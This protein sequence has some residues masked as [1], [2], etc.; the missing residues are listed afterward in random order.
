MNGFLATLRRR[1]V[2]VDPRASLAA[3]VAWLI[4]LLSLTFAIAA[5]MWV[6]RI[7]R[8]NVLQ[9]HT[10]RLALE[11]D[12]LSVA[13]GQ[14]LAARLDALSAVR[15][16][17]SSGAAGAPADAARVYTELRTHYPELD[18]LF[19][20][21]RDGA[22]HGDGVA[23]SPGRVA[24]ESWF[25][26][27]QSAPWIG[28][29][30]PAPVTA[31][32]RADRVSTPQSTAA[33]TDSLGELAAPIEDGAGHAVAVAVARLSWPR[34]LGHPQRLTDEL[35]PTAKARVFLLDER[36]H[37]LLGPAGFVGETWRGVPTTAVD[38]GLD[39]E[40]LPDG[41]QILV[42]REP[43]VSDPRWASRGWTVLLA[44]PVAR[45]YRRADA[46]AYQILLVSIALGV[47][48]AAL[49]IFGAQRLT[50]GLN[51]LTG[52]VISLGAHA[53]GDIAIPDGQDEVATLA[54]AF[55]RI[56]EDL[57]RERGELERLSADLE[58][59]VA[60]RTAEVQR[61]A[62]ESRYAAIVRERLQIARDLHDTL[63][64][65]L[66][67]LLSEIRL[68]R[69]LARR[70]P[71]A[72]EEELKRAEQIA[73]DGLNDARAAIEQMRDHPVREVG[74]GPVLARELERLRDRTG[75]QVEFHADPAAAG[76]GE[77]RAERLLRM[78]L[79]CLRNVERHARA[80]LVRLTLRASADTLSMLIEDDGIGF[81]VAAS[82]PGHYGLVGLREQAEMIGATLRLVSAPDLGTTVEITLALA[83]VPFA[84]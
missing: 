16:L 39:F 2:R 70:D 54:R 44:E 75:L 76:F 29:L 33:D 62:E 27:A 84:A 5:A 73:R 7:A 32:R 67:A 11:T 58:R 24:A 55:A 65:S 31:G 17:V 66:M 60:V 8:S 77:E 71:R 49:G 22:V 6:G 21:D 20:V 15:Q 63:A 40:R 14:A 10:R 80:S 9:Q 34:P 50:L 19:W 74:L 81:D 41:S 47:G 30:T 35:E 23:S 51:R 59:R 36:G 56:L 43:L 83:P 38:A 72:L 4:L 37:V 78:A 25:R 68:L 61:L 69:R 45:V 79:E 52:S 48:V 26:Q 3:R 42:A 1:L 28:R 53:A 18:W 82:H 64:H 12:Q 46:L 13:L 57:R